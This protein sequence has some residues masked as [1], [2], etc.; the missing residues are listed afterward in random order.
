MLILVNCFRGGKNS[1]L[2]VKILINLKCRCICIF[3]VTA[4]CHF[5][6]VIFLSRWMLGREIILYLDQLGPKII[7]NEYEL[8]DNFAKNSK[9]ETV[10][11]YPFI[12]GLV[13]CCARWG[14]KV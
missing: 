1:Y 3:P 12:H 2:C 7:L 8:I 14:E 10:K 5:C 13:P 9:D 11:D 6:L 4:F